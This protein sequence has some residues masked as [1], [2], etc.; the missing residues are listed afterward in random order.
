MWANIHIFTLLNVLSYCEI[1]PTWKSVAKNNEDMNYVLALI[2]TFK[3]LTS[4]ATDCFNSDQRIT[5]FFT[6]GNL[7]K[8]LK[9]EHD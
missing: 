6:E 7:T 2:V 8:A 1:I 4:W 9:N 5:L 3:N